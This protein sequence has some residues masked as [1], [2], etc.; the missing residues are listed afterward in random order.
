MW[1]KLSPYLPAPIRKLS[2]IAPNELDAGRR[3]DRI[4]ASVLADPDERQQFLE[5]LDPAERYCRL[6]RR[7]HELIAALTAGPP[8]D[9]N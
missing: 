4:A 8:S 7:A 2:D 5:E 6:V 3:A 1:Q 9:L